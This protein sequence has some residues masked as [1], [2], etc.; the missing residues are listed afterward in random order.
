MI[1]LKEEKVTIKTI[2]TEKNKLVCSGKKCEF[3]HGLDRILQYIIKSNEATR[4]KEFI[5][6][7]KVYHDKGENFS[8][9]TIALAL[10]FQLA[11]FNV[12]IINSKRP[13]RF[14]NYESPY[15]KSKRNRK[16]RY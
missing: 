3:N 14:P 10:E 1:N 2:K 13:F 16:I 4:F 11:G 6:L 8:N 9:D 5:K 12:K 7:K 15:D